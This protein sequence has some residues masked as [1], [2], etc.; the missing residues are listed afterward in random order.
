M[1]FST[2]E[3]AQIRAYLGYTDLFRYKNVR[4]E[5][6]LNGN[7]SVDAETLVRNNLAKLA[8]IDTA[9]DSGAGFATAGVEQLDEMKFFPHQTIKDLRA[10]GRSI[11]GRISTTIGVPPYADYYGEGGYPGD[12]Y[13]EFGLNGGNNG[14]I[15]RG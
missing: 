8:I 2:T 3:Q 5:G 10:I 7:L 15:P 4:L 1:A 14:L 11:I 6:V 12:T 13:S 9:I